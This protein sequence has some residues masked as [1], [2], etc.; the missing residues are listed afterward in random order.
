MG[1]GIGIG[2]GTGVGAGV[3]D[4]GAAGE[5]A[6]SSVRLVTRLWDALRGR[7][8]RFWP[9]PC[10]KGRYGLKIGVEGTVLVLGVLLFPLVRDSSCLN[11]S[12]WI[13]WG[14]EWDCCCD[15]D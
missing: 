8:K 14:P 7:R 5:G 4:D 6:E 2:T 13:C 15:C 1:I 12:S 3:P 10:I 11:S 9:G